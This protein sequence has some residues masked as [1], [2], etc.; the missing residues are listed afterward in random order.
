MIRISYLFILICSLQSIQLLAINKKDSTELINQLRVIENKVDRFFIWNELYHIYLYAGNSENTRKSCTEMNT[1]ANEINNDTLKSISYVFLAAYIS[2]A[3]NYTEATEYLDKALQLSV[4]NNFN[5]GIAYANKEKAIILKYKKNYD[6]AIDL[7]RVSI[8]NLPNYQ[9][10]FF[11]IY[12]RT[13]TQL[14]DIFYLKAKV[15]QNPSLLDSSD[16]YIKYSESKTDTLN[17]IYGFARN[18]HIKGLILSEGWPHKNAEPFFDSSIKYC[19]CN[20]S[21]LALSLISYDYCIF[22]INADSI[23][24]AKQYAYICIDASNKTNNLQTATDISKILRN[25]YRNEGKTAID[26]CIY[27][28]KLFDSLN[29]KI[30]SQTKINEYYNSITISKIR[31]DEERL[32]GIEKKQKDR[33]VLHFYAIASILIFI[34]TISIL[35]T[36]SILVNDWFLKSLGTLCFLITFE[37]IVL[38]IHF[39]VSIYAR[40]SFIDSPGFLLLVFVIMSLFWERFTHHMDPVIKKLIIKNRRIRLEAAKIRMQKASLIV[41]QLTKDDDK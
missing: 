12:N 5:V 40:D 6:E 20:Y 33:E 37:F 1:I 9:T 4:K 24:K 2:N 28:D 39:F 7:L 10:K 32:E 8:N 31:A 22:L 38:L 15:T 13:Y 30:N 29:E 3:G 11:R 27:Y 17:D 14:A 35:L 19:I 16:K 26:S 25:I 21:P 18:L 36:N 41:D 34:I 23:N